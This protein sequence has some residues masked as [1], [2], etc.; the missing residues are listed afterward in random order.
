M[1]QPEF[2]ALDLVL[3]GPGLACRK[4]LQSGGLF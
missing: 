1:I 3:T 2:I 4:N